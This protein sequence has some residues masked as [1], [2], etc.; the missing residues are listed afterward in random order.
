M[1]I[2][3]TLIRIN[4]WFLEGRRGRRR[5]RPLAFVSTGSSSSGPSTSRLRR[6]IVTHVGLD[7]TH[8]SE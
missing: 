2:G 5:G 1:G 4:C 7:H 8:T 3:T 6:G